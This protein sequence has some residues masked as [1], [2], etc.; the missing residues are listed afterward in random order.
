MIKLEVNGV[1]Y[2]GFTEITVSKS[3]DAVS[4][5]F[6]FSATTKDNIPFPIKVQDKCKIYIDDKLIMSGFVNSVDV[7][8]DASSHSISIRGR[9][10]TADIIDSTLN[11]KAEFKAGVTLKA[12][13]EKVISDL[14]ITDIEVIENVVIKKFLKNEIISDKVGQPAFEFI[15]SYCRKRQVIATTDENGNLVFTRAGTEKVPIVLINTVAGENNIL[16]ASVSWDES[17]RFNKYVCISQSNNAADPDTNETPK[18]QTDKQL[19]AIFDTKI[20][21]TRIFHFLPE[22]DLTLQE[23]AERSTWEANIRRARSFTYSVIVQ[24]HLIKPGGDIW[25]PN[26]LVSVLDEFSDVNAT[27]L[28]NTVE[29]NLSVDSGETTILGMVTKDAYTLE[30]NKPVKDEKSESLGEEFTEDS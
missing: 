30:A 14:N 28:I 17:N 9:D 27:L 23:T 22:N 19:P 2:I 8:Y 25:R 5:E 11:G 18:E 10:K 16:S 1:R 29:Y 3:L 20:R 7:S 21:D 12:V 6:S 13:A 24:G 4:G 15:E 26:K